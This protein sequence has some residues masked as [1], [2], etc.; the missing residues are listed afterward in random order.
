MSL[1]GCPPSHSARDLWPVTPC[2]TP[3]LAPAS[4]PGATASPRGA[5]WAGCRYPGTGLPQ[6]R[7]LL[8]GWAEPARAA[9]RWELR[10]GAP[11]APALRQRRGP[12]AGGPE[13]GRKSGR[14]AR[15]SHSTAAIPVSPPTMESTWSV[16]VLRQPGTWGC[17]EPAPASPQPHPALLHCWGS[18]GAQPLTCTTMQAVAVARRPYPSW[19]AAWIS[20]VYSETACGKRLRHPKVGDELDGG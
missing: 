4:L 16:S 17:W 10:P 12:G 1:P 3:S 20:S 19:S 5:G 14:W 9:S 18:R 6:N 2:K 13:P 7:V 8:P 11:R 15:R